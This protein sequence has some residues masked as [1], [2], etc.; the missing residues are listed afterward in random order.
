MARFKEAMDKKQAQ[1]AAESKPYHKTLTAGDR[2]EG[3]IYD[4]PRGQ[5]LELDQKPTLVIFSRYY[6][7]G[8]CQTL[9]SQL[10]ALWPAIQQAGYDLKVVLQ[11]TRESVLEGTKDNPY[12]FDLVCDP[13]AR[14]YDRYNIF[15]ADGALAMVGGSLEVINAL[16]GPG[17]LLGSQFSKVP[18]EGRSRQLPAAFLIGPDGVV[19]K[20]HYGQTIV[21]LPDIKEFLGI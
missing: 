7:C 6:T 18:T 20:A 19:Q 21:D 5:G 15:E 2:L 3:F 13:E 10:R 17:K 14:L 8:L 11:S 12:P 4:A 1:W 9:L 16:G